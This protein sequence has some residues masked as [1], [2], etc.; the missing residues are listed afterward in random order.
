MSL[1]RPIAT[2]GGLTMVSRILGFVRDVLIAA[3]LGAGPVADAFFVAF[4]LPNFFRRLF[5]EGAFNAAFIPLFTRRL[6]EGGTE[7]AR[8]FAE[9]IL[10]IFVIAL[11]VL[12]T[13]LQIFMPL[14]MLG[15]AP[16]FS[17]DPEKFDLA[18]EFAR[19]AF[20]YLLFISLVSQFGGVLNS[21]NRFA[22]AAATPI[23]LNL[24][25]IAALLALG[26]VL[27]TPGHALAWGA[28]GAGVIQFLWLV[29]ACRRAGM[30]FRLPRPRL[31][32]DVRRFLKLLLPG[33]LGAGVLQINTLVGT[34]LA[35]LLP[36]GAV[37]YLYYADRVHQLPLG[38]IGIAVGTALLPLLTRQLRSGDDMGAEDSMNRAIE[39][40]LLMT[41]PATAALIA[42]P[43]PIVA[44]LFER[45]AFDADA[46]VA[47]AYAL[48][49]YA[50]GLPAYVLIKV[51]APG[52]F[53]REDTVTPVRIATAAVVANIL[54]SLALMQPLGHVGL[55]LAT[56]LAAWLNAGWLCVALVRRGHLTF[57]DRVKARAG[58]IVI[59]SLIM[60]AALVGGASLLESPLAGGE[61]ERG[62]ALAALVLVGVAVYAV[63]VFLVRAADL[64]DLRGMVRRRTKR[65]G[66]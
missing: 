66:T 22:A 44:A 16:G 31:S 12:V 32:P 19:I 20:P 62:S 37:S 18:V 58:R 39:F 56:A 30:A 5:A 52:F 38:V 41:V 43:E 3:V 35:S 17:T 63:A 61:M 51:L 34:I 50:A 9:H 36:T 27:E 45:G 4:R 14:A 40:A 7:H 21:L 10:S 46:T 2:V 60:T 55:A 1:L 49:A 8:I 15:F 13:L 6:E 29:W 24:T 57:D 28:F 42:I 64:N 53:A 54:I 48:I 26:P 25:L 65:N 33:A 23:I 47:T 59:A 11:L